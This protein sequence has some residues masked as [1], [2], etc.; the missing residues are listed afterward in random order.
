M[1]IFVSPLLIV[2]ATLVA[3]PV[4]VFF[5]EVLSALALSHQAFSFGVDKI[6][7]RSPRIAILIPAHD[8]S[9]GIL[10]TLSDIKQQLLP[11]DRLLVVADNCT[12]DTALVAQAQGAEVI[13]RH[14]P[15]K[16]GK[17][18]ALDFG[19]RHL[20]SDP[21]EVVIMVDADCR[22][23]NDAI[24]ELVGACATMHRPVQALYLMTPATDG[25]VNHQ[26]AEF[27]W[28][29]KNSLRPSGLAALGLPCQLM[30][31]GMAFA[32][33]V[34]RDA[35]LAHGSVVEDVKLGLDLTSQGHPPLFCLSARVTSQFASSVKGA[36]SQ[37]ERWE[38]G[39]ISVILRTLP[40]TLF[41][42]IARR[43]WMLL[44]LTLDL[45]VPPLSLLAL[46]V[47]GMLT[48]TAISAIVGFSSAALIMSIVTLG[49][50]VLGVFL[51]WLQCGRNVVPLGAALSIPS[52][53]F[54]KLDL[55]R[56]ALLNKSNGRWIRTDRT[57]SE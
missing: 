15:A 21:P 53:V 1:E 22:V 26:V 55:Y 14:D 7:R 20:S 13:E 36:R 11:A 31:T 35:D 39:H 33:D 52:Y 10:P 6:N 18:Y 34:I 5:T 19:I 42:A 48:A 2:S 28:R 25:L 37:R 29:V 49:M 41:K 30:G 23:A 17:G 12:D 45:A 8:E 47:F 40:R 27:A 46:L 56:R 9:A 38:G 4:A 32:W 57:N 54:G 44:A 24:D 43:D 51:A 50:L 3:I 16:Q